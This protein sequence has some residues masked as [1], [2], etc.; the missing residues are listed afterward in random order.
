MDVPYG[1]GEVEEGPFALLEFSAGLGPPR[2]V[3]TSRIVTRHPATST[4]ECGSHGGP[5]QGGRA[6]WDPERHR[7]GI[8]AYGPLGPRSGGTRKGGWGYPALRYR[9][10]WPS[11]PIK[12][13]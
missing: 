6:R 9:S 7:A 3:A 4:E 8:A 12:A 1:I 13:L 5:A 2:P 11:R 10:A